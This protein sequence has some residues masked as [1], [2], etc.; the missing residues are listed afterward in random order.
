MSDCSVKVLRKRMRSSVKERVRAVLEAYPSAK[1]DNRILYYYL[2]KCFYGLNITFKKW[3]SLRR[4]PS[5]ET[6]MRRR[7]E[8]AQDYRRDNGLLADS[9]TP[10][11]PSG[12]TVRKRVKNEAVYREHYSPRLPDWQD[13]YVEKVV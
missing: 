3:E 8:L 2:L 13:I 4:A 10:F 1:G 5:P 7:R 6:A 11:D 12:A 9:P